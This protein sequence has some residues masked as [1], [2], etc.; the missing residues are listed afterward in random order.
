MQ[1]VRTLLSHPSFADFDVRFLLP[2]VT[3]L[4]SP[5]TSRV[6][7]APLGLVAGE[8]VFP[9]L[10]ARG[11][12]AVGRKVVCL[13][14]RGSAWPDLRRECDTFEWCRVARL[15]KWFRVL[16]RAGCSEAI[17]VGR[18]VKTR[19]HERFL[20]L[21]NL[22]DL[23]GLR[24]WWTVLRKDKRPQTVLSAMIDM[25]AAEG[26]PLIDSTQYCKEHLATA[27]VMTRT[28]PTEAQWQDV[29]YGWER[30][31]TISRLD[32]GQAIAVLDRDVL[33][34]EALEGTNAMIERAGALCRKG[35]WICI[36]VS[37]KNQDMRL[38]VPTVGATTIEKLHEMRASCLVL[39]P[40]KTIILEKPRV[41]ELADRH[42]IA[43]VGY[44]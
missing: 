13:G 36:K 40:G 33:A 37:N 17:M 23:R 28:Q 38:D 3:R 42:G 41:L 35:G 6:P 24:L 26:I 7:S 31:T 39:E 16:R 27:G 5:Q 34:V 30:C 22:P 14:F 12:R 11:A 29:R 43:I 18:V 32:I 10:V 19:M 1:E 8:G 20:A 4:A 2:L 9:L 44:E 25:F 15:G 21:R